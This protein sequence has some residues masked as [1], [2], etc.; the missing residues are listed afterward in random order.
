MIRELIQKNKLAIRFLV[1]FV[2]FYLIGN[3]LYGFYVDYY[4]PTSDPFTKNLANTITFVLQWF[5]P[6]IANYPSSVAEYIALANDQE[7]MI[8]IYEGCNGIN[9]MIVY[10]S[11]LLAFSGPKGLFWKFLLLGLLS[12]Y[13]M[14]L[15]RVG[16]LFG[17]AYYFE[18]QL[19]FF[20][21]YLFTGIIYVVVFALWYLWVKKVKRS[22]S[23]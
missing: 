12:I 10:I 19:Y 11:F 16:L 17:V 5:D 4:F 14:N 15:I 7:N 20:H 3:T 21:K 1:V 22:E 8:Y 18:E 9:V 13:L 6:T 2:G 23:A